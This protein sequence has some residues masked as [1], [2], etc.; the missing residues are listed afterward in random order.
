MEFPHLDDSR[1]PDLESV[2][3]YKYKNE[4]DYN[5]FDDVQMEL[6][7]CTVPWDMGEAHVGARTISGIGNVVDF[8]SK[9]ARNAWFDAIPDSKCFR[10]SSKYRSLQRDNEIIVPVPFDIASTYNYLYVHYPM[11]ASD[12]SPLKYESAGGHKDWFWFI[13]EVEFLA[14][15][16]TRLHLLPD[17]WQTFIYDVDIPSMV[18]ERGH[19]PMFASPVNSYL[20][21]PVSNCKYLLASDAVFGDVADIAKKEADFIINDGTDMMAVIVTS[22]NPRA[23]TWGFYPNDTAFTPS[24][25][26]IR[27]GV[28]GYYAFAVY[29]A[30]FQNFIN[31]VSYGSPHFLQT[32]KCIFFVSKKLLTLGT[33]FKF[34]GDN[35]FP[36]TAYELTANAKSN[37]LYTLSKADFGYPSEYANIAK[38]YTYPYAILELYGN[39]GSIEQIRIE[40]TDGS[41]QVETALNL[42][43]PWIA[44]DA[45]V[46]GVGKATSRTLT[47]ANITS[48]TIGAQ[49][50]WLDLLM[51]FEIPTFGIMQAAYDFDGYTNLYNRKQAAIAYGNE[52]N[53]SVAAADNETANNNLTTAN[54]TAIT[55]LANAKAADD[56]DENILYNN[57]MNAAANQ[58][59]FG[60]A[61]IQTSVE[62]Q[63]AN[64]TSQQGIIDGFLSGNIGSAI[65]GLVNSG[66]T[67]AGAALSIAAN[68]TQ[69]GMTMGYNGA[70]N[71]AVNSNIGIMLG[72]ATQLESDKTSAINTMLTAQTANTVAMLKANA[73]RTRSTAQNAVM[74]GRSN[75]GVGAPMEF[76]NFANG[77]HSTTRP[78][79]LFCVVKTQDES[80]IAQA[81][82]YFLRYGYA[83]N[84]NWAFDGDWT[85]GHKYCYW[86]LADF[87]VKGLDVPDMYMDRLR[88]F[89]FGGVTVWK[90]PEDIG[91]TT[92]YQLGA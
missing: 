56:A 47:F 12:S 85:Q 26:F 61:I 72:Y 49:G 4:L 86:K 90:R 77:Q 52:Y 91:N 29:V 22:A 34:N 13:R 44:C 76:G 65:S 15:N 36:V 73:T 11:M 82:D 70:V 63:N 79:G 57:D 24:G 92:I 17:A 25:L 3:V 33:S 2:D 60:Q 71:G 48:D 68:Q 39:D 62:Q 42:C 5:R 55:Q 46:K 75:A 20:A 23:T 19:A 64:L 45:H 35:N 80:A 1:F 28:P 84:G 78:T 81:G 50:N 32:I 41:L 8:G 59:I 43:Y 38:L 67:Q 7:L 51:T 37:D 18:L 40:S 69:T 27:D 21:N 87:W 6:T 31:T 54:N 53:S 9:K 88:F 66:F 16:S 58:Y 74:N 83:Y 30:N 10:F 14:P 89:L